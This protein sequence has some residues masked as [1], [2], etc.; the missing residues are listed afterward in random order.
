MPDTAVF[1]ST[2]VETQ[3]AQKYL[4][5]IVG[6]KLVDENGELNAKT[7][8]LIKEFQK[9]AGLKPTGDVDANLLSILAETA[10][11]KKA[12]YELKIGGK[13][14]L[15]TKAEHKDAVATIRKKALIPIASSLNVSMKE[16]RGLW[17]HQN[18]ISKGSFWAWAIESYAGG[19]NLPKESTIKAAEKKVADFDKLVRNGDLKGFDTS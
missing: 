15:M 11:Y 14:F 19:V 4:N 2:S 13:T 12:D 16:A 17:D 9:E 1:G 5:K 6:K 7:Q 10:R 3:R 18:E 8:K